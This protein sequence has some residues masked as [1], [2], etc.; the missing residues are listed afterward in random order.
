MIDHVTWV[1]YAECTNLHLYQYVVNSECKET[2]FYLCA[3]QSIGTLITVLENN[4][5]KLG[6]HF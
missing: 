1:Q 2:K 5:Q 6:S 4:D 3:Q